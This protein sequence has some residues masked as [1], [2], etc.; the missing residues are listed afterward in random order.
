MQGD[1]RLLRE[2]QCSLSSVCVMP[3]DKAINSLCFS[4]M[5]PCC[6]GSLRELSKA[7]HGLGL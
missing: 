3:M 2:S 5:A 7:L 4:L 6:H 1:A